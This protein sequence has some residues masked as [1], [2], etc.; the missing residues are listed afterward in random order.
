MW[1]AFQVCC[2]GI[3]CGGEQYLPTHTPAAQPDGGQQE[4]AE[5]SHEFDDEHWYLC[6]VPDRCARVDDTLDSPSQR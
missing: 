5:V 3:V 6:G 1:G 2:G 4:G